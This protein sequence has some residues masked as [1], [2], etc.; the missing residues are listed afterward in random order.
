MKK[1]GT[2][3]PRLTARGNKT[4]IT[5]LSQFLSSQR[6]GQGVAEFLAQ[7]TNEEL[8]RFL[9]TPLYHA[10][11]QVSHPIAVLFGRVIEVFTSPDRNGIWVKVRWDD[12]ATSEHPQ[13]NVRPDL[14]EIAHDLR[15]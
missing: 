12:G 2:T 3:K 4:T 6:A 11:D 13:L 5:L 10:G 14:R 9:H 8:Q 1:Q 15:R 7:F